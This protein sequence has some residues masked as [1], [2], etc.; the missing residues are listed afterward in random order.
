MI[1]YFIKNK[2]YL[3]LYY[4]L[5]QTKVLQKRIILKGNV[6]KKIF[7]KIK[8]IYEIVIDG[9]SSTYFFCLIVLNK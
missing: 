2:F 9:A 1:D 3:K 6:K 4:D 8:R 5:E 7:K